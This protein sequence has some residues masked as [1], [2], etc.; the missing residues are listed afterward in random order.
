MAPEQDGWPP[1]AQEDWGVF[2]QLRN[3]VTR[4]VSKDKVVA[5]KDQARRLAEDPKG[6]KTWRY[7]KKRAGWTGGGNPTSLILGQ[8]LEESPKRIADAM[9]THF[10]HK[11]HRIQQELGPPCMDPTLHLKARMSSWAEGR[12]DQELFEVTPVPLWK[13]MEVL[14]KLNSGRSEGQDRLS[15]YL[16]RLGREQLVAPLNHLTNTIIRKHKFPIKLK[17]GR[18]IPLHKGRGSP[19]NM[20]NFRP[21][22]VLSPISAVVES[23][24]Q[25]QLDAH[26][27]AR[28]LWH[29]H[30][31][32]YRAAY[33]TTTA[34]LQAQNHWMDSID[35]SKATMNMLLDLT[36]A[37]DCVQWGP[38][39]AKL[40]CYSVGPGT[41]ELMR[42]FMQHR[43]QYVAI[44]A[45]TSQMKPVLSGVPQ[46]ST[47][48]PT[49]Y[50]LY[51]NELQGLPTIQCQHMQENQGIRSTLWGTT[52]LKCG[53]METY[54]DDSTLIIAYDRGGARDQTQ[55]G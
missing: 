36:A 50:N 9:V 31:H 20:G 10:T 12:L 27:V 1:E 21:V 8:T 32:A 43:T 55:A 35:D 26:M 46:G 41:I 37:F 29:P 16:I 54:A 4:Q 49:V 44:G 17:I 18:V 28:G 15:G 45:S 3:R 25:E 34:L 30:Q 33:S 47:L 23:S 5:D 11:V 2:R 52:C 14:K 7:V 19:Q 38:L 53:V 51:M 13:T 24:I 6:D 48:E 39:A 22:T 42:T 40:Q